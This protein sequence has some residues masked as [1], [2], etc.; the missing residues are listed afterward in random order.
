[1]PPA[2]SGPRRG[3]E[4]PASAG[5]AALLRVSGSRTV[6]VIGAPEILL[7]RALADEGNASLALAL[8]GANPRLLWFLPRPE[9]P[10]AEG[11]R[12]LGELVHPGWVWATVQLGV[13]AAL[14][15]LWRAR[16]L[17]PVVTEPLPVV[18]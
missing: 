7:N 17:G 16:R 18:V 10:A 5:G 6:T 11:E 14:A 12:S 13:A 15:M 1:M 8:L 9:G 2:A 3:A 4:G